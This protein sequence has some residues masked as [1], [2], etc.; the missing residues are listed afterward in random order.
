MSEESPKKKLKTWYVQSFKDEWLEDE[1]FKDW[2]KKDNV[3][4]NNSYCVCCNFTIKNA[5]KIYVI[6]S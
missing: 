1:N 6:E 5:G 2:L 4:K 3:N